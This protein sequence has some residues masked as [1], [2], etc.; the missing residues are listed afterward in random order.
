MSVVSKVFISLNPVIKPLLQS[1]WHWLLSSQLMLVR[2]TGR[3]S[4]REFTTPMFYTTF[5]DT[6]I[7]VL[8]ETQGRVW[9]KN[10]LDTA[11]MSILVRGKWQEG[12]A[13][14]LKPED[15]EYKKWFEA[16]FNLKPYITGIFHTQYNRKAGLSKPQ[17]DY[18]AKR[19][20]IVKFSPHWVNQ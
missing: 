16:V 10:Y 6:K 2:F 1:K 11:P 20:G 13:E 8:A 15:P 17:I 14:M 4:G 18:L 19:S 7:I 3:K 12:F 5:N 9:W